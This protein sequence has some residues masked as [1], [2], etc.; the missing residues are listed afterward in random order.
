M[1]YFK[2][3]TPTNHS[4]FWN[5][6]ITSCSCKN[7][8]FWGTLCHHVLR[9]FSYRDY[10]KIPSLYLPLCWHHKTLLSSSVRDGVLH[11]TSD[12]IQSTCEVEEGH[13][14]ATT[15]VVDGED[16]IMMEKEVDL[17][18]HAFIDGNTVHLPPKSKKLGKKT[19][20]C[21]VCKQAGHTKP[22][23]PYKET[24]FGLNGMKDSV[25]SSQKR[26]K[27]TPNALGMNPIFTLKY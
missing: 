12:V 23:C 5:R 17:M 21:S 26:L 3:V 27:K 22:T 18:Y 6:V 16:S 1:R 14:C 8:E 9:V 7:F 11:S 24:F 20:C 13:T 19:K 2:G 25:S 4:I 15:S 10:F